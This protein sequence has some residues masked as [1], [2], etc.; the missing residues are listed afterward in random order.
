MAIV[1]FIKEI[2]ECIA[3]LRVPL[4]LAS[5]PSILVGVVANLATHISGWQLSCLDGGYRFFDRPATTRRNNQYGNGYR[6]GQQGPARSSGRLKQ[7][8][9]LRELVYPVG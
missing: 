7:L 9:Q 2:P 4:L 3:F 6:G 5:S 8:V 1:L